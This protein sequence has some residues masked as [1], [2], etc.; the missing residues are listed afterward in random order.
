MIILESDISCV[1]N[2]CGIQ[3]LSDE[4]EDYKKYSCSFLGKFI[5]NEEQ[6]KAKSSL[7]DAIISYLYYHSDK[8]VIDG[9]NDKIYFIGDHEVYKIYFSDT[10][11]TVFLSD[12]MIRNF[13]PKS[14]SNRIETILSDFNKRSKY[15]GEVITFSREELYSALFVTRFDNEGKF[16]CFSDMHRQSEIILNYFKQEG[17]I[18]F[19]EKVSSFDVTLMPTGWMHSEELIKAKQDIITDSNAEE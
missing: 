7:F 2:D 10:D 11:D 4:I 6:L 9:N 3:I 5:T 17:Y 15:V 13:Y 19:E 18:E 1:F 14:F 8:S 12:T 16:V